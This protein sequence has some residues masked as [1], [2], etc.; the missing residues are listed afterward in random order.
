MVS[1]W[2]IQKRSVVIFNV[3]FSLN[4]WSTCQANGQT[5]CDQNICLI[6]DSLI[7]NV[8]SIS[9]TLGWRAANYSEFWGREYSEGLELRLGTK[10]PNKKV[11]AMSKLSIRP[12]SLP[13]SFNALEESKWAGFI[14][15]I[16]DQ[17][18]CGSSWAIST[19]AV[20]SDRFGIQTKGKE[21]VVLSP[22]QLLSCVRKQLGC[23]GGH[24]DWAWNYIRKIG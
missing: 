17:G 12:E 23:A 24:L 7:S 20:A 21:S 6:D 1:L 2:S 16:H 11:K 14:S 5:V 13:R 18:W 19:A 8:N 4:S 3:N 9:N 15:P 22:Q 10:E